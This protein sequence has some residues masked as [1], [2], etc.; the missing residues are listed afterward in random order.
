MHRLRPFQRFTVP[1]ATRFALAALAFTGLS[2]TTNPAGAASP[3][4]TS[5]SS[6][7][8]KTTAKP[9]PALPAVV[10]SRGDA[11]AVEVSDVSRIVALNGDVN[12]I[13]YALGLGE[14]IVANDI[15]ATFPA[16]ATKKPKIGYGR[17]LS[18]EGLLALKPTLIIGN[19]DAGPAT[20]VAQLRST[21]IPVVIVPAG[22]DVGDAAKKIRWVAK[23]VGLSAAG[24]ALAD[25]VERD[26]AA[27]QRRWAASARH[28][29]PKAVFLYLRGPKTQLLG[30]AGTRA[31]AMLS[32]AGATDAG[33]YLA[34]VTGYVPIT[35]EALVRA[36]PDTIVVLEDGLASVGGVD[37]LLRGWTN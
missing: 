28:L 10:R 15:T 18:A 37:G 31:H 36:K 11:G 19:E 1:F 3:T 30:G 17:Q 6:A 35:S 26:I 23:A 4:S 20:V 9:K 24:E 22:D 27:V 14:N 34:G 25:T 7:A 29:E 13:L 8:T 16:D 32:A 5:T 2:V 21:N 33:A 12:E